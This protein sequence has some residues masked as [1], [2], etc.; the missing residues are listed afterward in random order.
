[1]IKNG[2]STACK[3]VVY[4]FE[5]LNCGFVS[6]PHTY[7]HLLYAMCEKVFLNEAETFHSLLVH[8]IARWVCDSQVVS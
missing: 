2:N 1:M 5:Y 7:Q 6:E 4:S 8:W 3:E